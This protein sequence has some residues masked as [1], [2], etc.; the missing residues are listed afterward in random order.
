MT[1]LGPDAGAS[2]RG[3]MLVTGR[4]QQLRRSVVEDPVM[5]KQIRLII[6][7]R[8]GNHAARVELLSTEFGVQANAVVE[9]HEPPLVYETVQHRDE[10]HS[11]FPDG[12]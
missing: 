6:M 2:A 5:R 7:G 9:Q 12:G 1:V 4:P 8:T 3:P 11:L 10:R